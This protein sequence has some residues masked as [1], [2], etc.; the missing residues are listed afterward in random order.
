M[1]KMAGDKL[2]IISSLDHLVAVK[3]HSIKSIK[4]LWLSTTL[5]GVPVEPEVLIKHK[6]LVSITFLNAVTTHHVPAILLLNYQSIKFVQQD[7]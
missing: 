3:A 5:L 2:P 4:L 1:S 7:I 6:G